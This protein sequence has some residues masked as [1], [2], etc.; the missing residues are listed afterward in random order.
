MERLLEQLKNLESCPVSKKV[1]EPILKELR[2]Q[3]SM[4]QSM[5]GSG[6]QILDKVSDLMEEF[7]N[8]CNEVRG[9]CEEAKSIAPTQPVASLDSNTLHTLTGMYVLT[10][11][12]VNYFQPLCKREEIS[13]KVHNSFIFDCSILS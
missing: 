5:Q 9:L 13:Y 11:D 10:W 7:K 6:E 4:T 1:K 3:L 8:N 2:D 12:L